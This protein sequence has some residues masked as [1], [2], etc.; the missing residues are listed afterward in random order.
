MTGSL[1]GRTRHVIPRWRSVRRTVE[2][3]EF[4]QRLS[5]RPSPSQSDDVLADVER[6]WK[7]TKDQVSAAELVS[8]GLILGRREHVRDAAT[9]LAS[10][11]QNELLRGLGV[12]A[13]DDSQVAGLRDPTRPAQGET[14]ERHLRRQLHQDRLNSTLDPRNALTWATMA[15]RYTMLGQRVQADRALTVALSFAPSSRYVHRIATRFYV[16]IGEPER[17]YRL[18]QGFGRTQTDPWLLAAFLAV[19]N[20]ADLPTGTLRP[21]RRI[22]SESDFRPIEKAELA[23]ELGT[24]EMRAGQD[25]RARQLF[26][27]SLERPTDNSLAQAEWASHHLAQLEVPLD[28]ET[29]FAAEARAL[30]AAEGGEWEDALVQ[31]KN[32][33]DDQPFDERA[34]IHGSFVAAVALERWDD[35]IAIARAGLRSSPRHPLLV[36]N[37]AFALIQD[38]N[39]DEAERVLRTADRSTASPHDLVSLKA[40]EGLLALRRGESPIGRTLYREAIA[41]AHKLRSDRQEAMAGAMLLQEIIRTHFEDESVPPLIVMLDELTHRLTDKAVLLTIT[42][43]ESLATR[44]RPQRGA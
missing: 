26:R 43:A 25:R 41:S 35:S 39:L 24:M 22:I 19:A 8:A 40:T 42:R 32:W 12:R 15:R 2:A 38:G 37:L 44:Q 5:S 6:R 16:H 21:A 17:A 4:Q 28:D 27:Q 9:F 14:F 1:A 23:S 34:A 20:L 10:V 18:L 36:N 13:L 33:L 31:A 7:E 3:G 11:G 29:P 30:S